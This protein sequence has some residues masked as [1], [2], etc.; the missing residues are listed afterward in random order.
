MKD[1]NQTLKAICDYVLL[2][3]DYYLA[4][5]PK[6]NVIFFQK[7]EEFIKCYYRNRSFSD[8]ILNVKMINHKLPLL[9]NLCLEYEKNLEKQYVVQ[10]LGGNDSNLNKYIQPYQKFLK[11]EGLMA[12]V[13]D[14]SNIIILGSGYL[15]GTAIILTKIFKAKI[16]CLDND[17]DA[18]KS[19]GKLIKQLSLDNRIRVEFGDASVYPLTKYD[20]IIVTG[21]CFPKKDI[22]DHISMEA[23]DTKIIYRSPRGLYKMWYSPTTAEEINRFK[24]IEK[25]DHGKDYP[26]ESVLL[27]KKT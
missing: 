12:G 1:T 2:Y 10:S 25:L 18:V 3:L 6:Q 7:L 24:I 8:Y 26:F 4:F 23:K 22:F 27:T 16:T 11:K 20:V 19:S 14:T 15:P 17:I 13:K 9:R 5:S 21:S